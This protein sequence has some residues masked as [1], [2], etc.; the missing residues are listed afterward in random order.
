LSLNIIG[1]EFYLEFKHD[2][3]DLI[4]IRHIPNCKFPAIEFKYKSI[5]YHL[6]G[7]R[8]ISKFALDFLLRRDI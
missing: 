5:Q 7:W 1:S 3:P 6:L 8:A 4:K 2:G